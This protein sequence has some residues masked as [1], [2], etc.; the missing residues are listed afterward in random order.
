MILRLASFL[1]ILYA[2]GFLLFAVTLGRPAASD[3]KTD[4]LIVITGGSGRVEHG[5]EVLADKRARRLLV[6][7]ADPLVTKPDLVRIHAGRGQLLRC[8]VDLGSD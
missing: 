8:C 3:R 2:L 1:V 6:A 4:A 5:L 7:G